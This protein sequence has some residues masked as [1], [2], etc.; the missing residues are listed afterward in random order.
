ME[1]DS[2]NL[3]GIHTALGQ[4]S[5]FLFGTLLS[6]LKSQALI[7]RVGN[8][9]RI[10]PRQAIAAAQIHQNLS[11]EGHRVLVLSADTVG[12]GTYDRIR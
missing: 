3:V 4:V 12:E 2:C 5:E 10:L 8:T 6:I 1:F 11:R 7:T 9:G